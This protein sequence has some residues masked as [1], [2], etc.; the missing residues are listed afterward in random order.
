MISRTVFPAC[1]RFLLLLSE[2]S[3]HHRARPGIDGSEVRAA[4]SNPTPPPGV[5]PSFFMMLRG[6][7]FGPKFGG[8][9]ALSDFQVASV[10]AEAFLL[11]G[12]LSPSSPRVL[13]ANPALTCSPCDIS[14]VQRNASR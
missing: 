2:R 1:L 7:I 13:M 8:I 12:K 9:I 3:A 14:D 11:L 4:L 5:D 6:A 10:P